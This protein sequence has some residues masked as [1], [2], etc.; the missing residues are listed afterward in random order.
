MDILWIVLAVF[1]FIVCA[2]LLVIEIFVPSFGILS[3]CAI[4]CLIAG[5]TIFFDYGLVSGWV[6]VGIAAVVIPIIWILTYRLFPKTSIG[7]K[8]ILEKPDSGRGDA[9]PDHDQL[10]TMLHKTGIVKTPLRP[11]GTCEFDGQK[12]ECVSETGYIERSQKVQVIRVEGTQLT[13]RLVSEDMQ[14]A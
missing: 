1:L 8:L 12:L 13:V 14:D 2:I 5:G 9:I 10:Q 7:K 11:V 3:V 4:A 6:G